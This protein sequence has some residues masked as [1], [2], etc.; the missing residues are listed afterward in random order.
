MTSPPAA[1][2][3]PADGPRADGAAAAGLPAAG[4]RTAG[5]APD[6]VAAVVLAAGEGRRLRPLTGIRPKALC[7]VGNVTLLDRAL[8]RIAG[9]GLAGPAAVAV[10][11]C[12]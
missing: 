6:A 9:L 3:L 2:G 4:P 10:N 12:H 11:A 7:P 1:A 5:F 8:A